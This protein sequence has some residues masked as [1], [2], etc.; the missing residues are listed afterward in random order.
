MAK[1]SRSQQAR[2]ISRQLAAQQ[3]KFARIR[4]RQVTAQKSAQAMRESGFNQVAIRKNFKTL[5]EQRARRKSLNKSQAADEEIEVIEEV[6]QSEESALKFNK[7]NFEL[8]EKTLLIL[9]DSI[10]EEDSVEDI[11]NKV[12][13]FYPDYTLAD[14]ALDF[15]LDTTT[16][17][18]NAKVGQAKEYLNTNFKREITAGRNINFQAQTFS[19]EGLGSPS[20]LR[21]MYREVTGQEQDPHALFDELSNKFNYDSMKIVIRFMLHSLGAD[22]KSKGPSIS[23]A[24]LQKLMEDMQILQ[25]ISGVYRFFMSRNQL[26]ASMFEHYG[27]VMLP[28]LNFEVMAK[29]FMKL[30]KERYVSSDKVKALAKMLGISE[31]IAA[32]IIIYT[33]MRDAV[34]GTS[35]RLYKSQKHRQDVL[36]AYIEALEDLEDELEEEEE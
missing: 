30:L 25:A 8:K 29:A 16:G 20:A 2:Q 1:V 14:D 11:L 28:I 17:K 7:K 31:E 4:M 18:L 35:F 13:N 26:I 15:L 24:E 10:T 36:A 9:R 32:Q 12:L 6:K 33:Q 21:D 5:E 23:R 34:R 27:L 19:K 3:A 22:L